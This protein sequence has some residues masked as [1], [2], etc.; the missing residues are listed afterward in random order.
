LYQSLRNEFNIEFDAKRD[1]SDLQDYEPGRKKKNRPLDMNETPN[2]IDSPQKSNKKVI[3]TDDI[4]RAT[5][6]GRII[7][8][9]P[10]GH[11]CRLQDA[12]S[13]RLPVAAYLTLGGCED[14][15]RMA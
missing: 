12:R 15:I 10:V 3:K 8:Q 13:P 4:T 11:S 14:G 2:A 1:T 6:H 9:G 5:G 7:K